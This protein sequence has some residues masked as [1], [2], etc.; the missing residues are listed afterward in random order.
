MNVNLAD[1]M[2]VD[3]ARSRFSELIDR[4]AVGGPVL[5]T[6]N[7]DPAAVMIDPEDYDAMVATLEVLANPELRHEIEEALDDIA[8]G[9]VDLIPHEDVKR[10]LAARRAHGGDSLAPPS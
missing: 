7:G 9:R 4:L 10:K 3:K 5:I 1:V 8:A 6:K 2:G